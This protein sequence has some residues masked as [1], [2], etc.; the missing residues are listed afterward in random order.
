MSNSLTIVYPFK[1]R[2]IRRVQISL[3]SLSV[4]SNQDFQVL[5]IDY[6]SDLQLAAQVEK[7]VSGYNFASYQYI[8][9]QNT[10][11]NKSRVLN[12]ALKQVETDY[13]FV[14]DVDGIF[15]PDF[16]QSLHDLSEADTITYFKV[17]YLTKEESATEKAFQD[18]T[19]KRFSTEEATGLS[20]FPVSILKII[21]GFDEYYHL[22][23]SEDTDVHVRAFA[24]GC[25]VNF[26]N[27]KVKILHQWH[28][29][30]LNRIDTVFTSRITV[31]G[32]A[33]HNMKYLDDLKA[34][35]YTKANEDFNWGHLWTKEQISSLDHPEIYVELPLNK[36]KR[37]R[38][39]EQTDYASKSIQFTA[40]KVNS[41]TALLFKITKG[42]TAEKF[43]SDEVLTYHINN[44]RDLP[45]SY[46][47][48]EEKG[49]F[50][51]TV[52]YV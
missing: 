47:V 36:K 16:V 42:I 18:Y 52:N 27:A 20:L 29:I 34:K 6:G 35:P 48:N 39:L 44:W 8:A 37:L 7:L 30:Y 2:D 19:V 49:T 9:A 11:W 24:A 40:K 17:G 3:N 45:Y 22:W 13:F 21:N 32:I 41:L 25:N 46:L 33:R 26:Y 38:L 43:I 14:A 5:F 31:R 23:G 51:Y 1:D 4:Q 15:A 10:L 50:S 28:E 12:I